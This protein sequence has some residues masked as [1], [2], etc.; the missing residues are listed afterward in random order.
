M[1]LEELYGSCQGDYEAAK[2]ILRMDKM[3]D[4][5]ILKFPKDGSMD[6]LLAAVESKNAQEIFEASHSLKGV[7]ANIGLISLSKAAGKV[8]DA[9]RP[10]QDCAM[11]DAELEESTAQIR[12]LY[13]LAISTIAQY[14]QEKA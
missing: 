7:C 9:Y 5:F 2:K 6:R 8:S 3:I 4:R 13:D 1:T 14:E 12:E 11:T 10:G